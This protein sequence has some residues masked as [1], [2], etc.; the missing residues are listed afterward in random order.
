MAIMD[1]KLWSVG[2]EKP[3]KY[4]DRASEKR[5]RH[6]VPLRVSVEYQDLLDITHSGQ[7]ALSNISSFLLPFKSKLLEK[8]LV[9]HLLLI[10]SSQHLE[11]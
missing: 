3:T 2:L 8:K 7:S 10:P 4:R 1:A 6:L 11:S 9:F 5:V